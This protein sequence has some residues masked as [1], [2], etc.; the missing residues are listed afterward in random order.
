MIRGISLSNNLINSLTIYNA[1]SHVNGMNFNNIVG[2]FS[3][4]NNI[5]MTNDF[6]LIM[7]KSSIT[8]M[9]QIPLDYKSTGNDRCLCNPYVI[10]NPYAIRREGIP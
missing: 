10:R 7:K 5:N 8:N 1:N 4:I 2:F 3:K 6:M 9:P